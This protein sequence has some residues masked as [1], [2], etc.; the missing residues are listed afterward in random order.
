MSQG[1]VTFGDGSTFEAR[2][3]D[4]SHW[5][6]CRRNKELNAVCDGINSRLMIGEG[7]GG[8]GGVRHTGGVVRELVNDEQICQKWMIS[9]C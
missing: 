8:G 3:W 7:P 6:K 9:L 4:E 5:W 1:A 2:W